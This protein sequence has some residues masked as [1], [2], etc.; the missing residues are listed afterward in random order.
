MVLFLTDCILKKCDKMED[1]QVCRSLLSG[2]SDERVERILRF[3]KEEDRKRSAMAGRLM[4][5][6]LPR[7]GIDV[8]R[9]R[10]TEKGRPY[11]EEE[12]DFN[13]S[14]SGDYV[15]LAV[16][17]RRVGCDIE[18][19]RPVKGSLLKY[20][21]RESEQEWIRTF[22]EEEQT[23]AFYRIWTAKES[24]IKMTGEGLTLGFEKYEIRAGQENCEERPGQTLPGELSLKS[25]VSCSFLGEMHVIR[26]GKAENCRILQMRTQDDYILSVCVDTS[27]RRASAVEFSGR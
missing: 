9:I 6:E 17:G 12:I 2:L 4:R 16:S 10:T 20:C 21:C 18:Q 5:D 13:L 14:H 25:P 22:P 8:D 24:Y 19:V 27:A 15:L 3:K 23:E 1:P 11:A 26:E 7:Y